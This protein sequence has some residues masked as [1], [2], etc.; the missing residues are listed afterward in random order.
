MPIC[1]LSFHWSM[2]GQKYHSYKGVGGTPISTSLGASLHTRTNILWP[3]L[4]SMRYRQSW[5]MGMRH[6]TWK[7]VMHISGI[8]TFTLTPQQ[9]PRATHLLTNVLSKVIVHVYQ[10][11]QTFSKCPPISKVDLGFYDQIGLTKYTFTCTLHVLL[12]IVLCAFVIM[13][14]WLIVKH[15]WFL[16]DISLHGHLLAIILWRNKLSWLVCFNDHELLMLEHQQIPKFMLFYH[17]HTR[18]RAWVKLGDA[19]EC[20]IHPWSLSFIVTYSPLFAS[21]VMFY[22]CF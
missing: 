9:L 21:N 1:L 20:K 8:L 6:F 19:D 22:S 10:C 17:F 14:A 13:Q 16:Y 18:G 15:R 4:S 2:D 3:K 12:S 11:L 5:S 7:H